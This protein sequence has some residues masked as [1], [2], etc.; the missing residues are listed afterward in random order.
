MSKFSVKKPLT[1]FV[2]VIAILVLGYVSFT[3][4]TPDLLPNIDMP[5]AVVITTYPGASPEKVEETVTKPLEQTMATLENIEDISST[6]GENYSSI[7]LKFADNVN[8]DTV[9]VDI[10]QKITQ[11]QG[12]WDEMV[13][14]PFILKLNPSMLPV[15]VGAINVEGMDTVQL[16]TFVDDVLMNKLEG[17][18]GVA[19]IS[20]TG[21]I[22]ERTN[23]V[24]RQDKIDALNAEI[25]AAIQ[26]EFASSE[27]ELKDARNEIESGLNKITDGKSKLQEGKD[28]FVNKGAEGQ[29]TLTQKQ[30]ELQDGKLQLNTQLKALKD[31]KAQLEQQQTQ[32][33]GL[34][35]SIN[36]LENNKT[37]LL[38]AKA[39]L[40]RAKLVPAAKYVEYD[41]AVALIVAQGLPADQQQA[42]IMQLIASDAEYQ[43]IAEADGVLASFGTAR[44][45]SDLSA[46]DTTIAI[47]DG[48]LAVVQNGLDTINLTLTTMGI[49]T[50]DI[51]ATLQQLATGLAQVNAGIA[52]MEKTLKQLE[53][54][55]IQL[56][57]A[58]AE[59]NRTLT[60]TSF[61]LNET[62]AQLLVGESTL[63]DAKKQLESGEK[64]LADAKDSALDKANLVN[65]ITRD[66]VSNILKAQNFSMP[67]GYVTQGGVDYL[68]S[69][70][71]SFNSPEE[72]SNL[73]LFDMGMDNIAPIYL[74][75]VADV[76]ISSN[77]DSVYARINGN[78]G[79]VLSF[80]KQSTNATAEVSGNIL[81][82][83]KLLEK[84]Y[85]GLSFVSLM[86]QGDYIHVVVNSILENLLLGALFAV[87]VLFLFLRDL[88]PTFITLCSIPISVIFAITLMYFSGVTINIISLSGLAVAVGMLVDN[89]VVVIENIYRLRSLGYSAAKAAVSGASQVAGAI[90]S[91][92]LTTVCVF[93]PI[94]FVQGITRQLFTDLALTMGYSL[95]A[96][97]VVALTLV[98]AMSAGMLK[99]IKQPKNTRFDKMLGGYKKSLQF[100]LKHKAPVLAGTLALLVISTLLVVMRGFAFMPQMS[101]GQ[102]TVTVTMPDGVLPEDTYAMA[103]TVAQK[104]SSISGVETVGA[105]TS[106]NGAGGM[107]LGLGGG[108][109]GSNSDVTIYV[110][111]APDAAKRGAQITAEI[112]NLT[113]DLDCE[114][115]AGSGTGGNLMNAL[116][117]SGISINVYGTDLKELQNTA[118]NVAEM[119]AQVPGTTNVQDGIGDTGPEIRF[120]VDKRKAM[121]EGLTVAQ[122][123]M[124]LS[125]ALT[126]EST[127]TTIRYEGSEIDVMVVSGQKEDLTPEYIKSKT[128]TVTNF[129]GEEKTI[130][131]SDI[132]EIVDTRTAVSIQRDN[133][134]RF[135]TVTAEVAEGS[136]VSLVTADAEKA[137]GS[138]TLPS[139]ITLEFSGENETIMDSFKELGSMLLLGVLLVYLIMVAQFQSLKSPFIVMFTIPLAF[140]GGFIALLITGKEL[141]VIALIGFVMLVGIIVN[142]GIVLVDYIN[143]LRIGGMEKGEALLD[144]GVTRMRPILMTS[145]TT[146]LGLIMMALGTGTGSE[147]M[148]PVAIVCIGGLVY[149]TA[150]TLYVVPVMYDIFNRKELHTVSQDDLELITE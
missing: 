3:S 37:Q 21:L 61:T 122:V 67:A 75:D 25:S 15:M 101:I 106:G 149:A 36:Q 110:I 132:A 144:A 95:M 54:G 65:I 72:L 57:T 143:Q 5:Y 136:N 40:E 51:P 74:R 83:F 82:K 134:R 114:V 120:V 81:A 92:T 16:S 126:T 34:Q 12:Q 115:N 102:L 29:G 107:G 43:A 7:V 38:A 8:M 79:V 86:D 45:G 73:L 127:S 93:L 47:I 62:T 121:Q 10:L 22:E 146:V 56:S 137:L 35:T 140:T 24:I 105:M 135:I 13:G 9:T 27:Q 139:G 88:R 123:Y 133:Q 31:T 84:E 4:M 99:N 2:A 44:T 103:D 119:L 46:I 20:A 33:M 64:Q 26:G 124:E 85:P 77:A 19:S 28:A 147:L 78:D 42:Q 52:T 55:S 98:P 58:V 109:G 76:Y 129:K 63:T 94:V 39:V 68:V 90:A 14:T 108:M 104:I 59:M 96:S 130:A 48:N 91:S 118:Q 125:K 1:V 23:V 89:S 50:G 18:P 131:I 11:M 32:L 69:V 66:Q 100:A 111:L 80:N 116:G 128:F 142:N 145:I 141:S 148:Q 97:L 87:I 30:M 6:S 60:A 112:E 117:G 70:G 113:K 49:S 17:I 150:L 71:E 53:D 41:D 138:L